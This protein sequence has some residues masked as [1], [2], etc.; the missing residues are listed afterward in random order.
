[1]WGSAGKEKVS[2]NCS[3]ANNAGCRDV[4]IGCPM[5]MVI[6]QVP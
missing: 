5:R 1:M 4:S 6:S 3:G 2:T